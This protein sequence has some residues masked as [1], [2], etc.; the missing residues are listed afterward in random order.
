MRECKTHII[1]LVIK[2]Q[3]YMD[4]K[5]TV[6]TTH[7]ARQIMGA[8]ADTMCEDQI[9]AL[10]AYTEDVAKWLL[11]EIMIRKTKMVE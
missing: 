4:K 6:L 11:E 5:Q 3:E 2:N 9:E 7:E 10:I 8:L 1:P